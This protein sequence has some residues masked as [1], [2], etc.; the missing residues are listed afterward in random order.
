MVVGLL[1]LPTLVCAETGEDAWL[2]YAR[3][4]QRVAQQYQSLPV[5]VVALGDSAVIH[6][7]QQELIR[8]TEGL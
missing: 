8:G 3:L 6:N 5:T 1:A 4:E 2:R 7:A